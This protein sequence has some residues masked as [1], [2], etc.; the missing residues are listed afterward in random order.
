MVLFSF[1]KVSANLF[2]DLYVQILI[3]TLGIRYHHYCVKIGFLRLTSQQ[4]R[5]G[6]PW[7][8]AVCW[9]FQLRFWRWQHVNKLH[10]I[11]NMEK[12]SS[13]WFDHFSWVKACVTVH[14][15]SLLFLIQKQIISLIGIRL[16]VRFWQVAVGGDEFCSQRAASHQQE[17]YFWTMPVISSLRFQRNILAGMAF[18]QNI[19]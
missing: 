5:F 10:A 16:Q 4:K 19:L 18:F 11:G 2:S 12:M 14:A 17:N 7:E 3:N 1:E 13:K 15:E 8:S 6:I 9:M